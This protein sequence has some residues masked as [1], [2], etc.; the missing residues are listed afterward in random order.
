MLPPGSA[1][2]KNRVGVLELH[3]SL[4]FAPSPADQLN[5][6]SRGVRWVSAAT[7]AVG[8]ISTCPVVVN[9]QS[10]SDQ[11]GPKHREPTRLYFGMWTTHLKHDVVALHNNWVVG[12]TYRG[13]FGAT[14]LNS[15]GR[16]AFTGGIQRTILATEPRPIGASLGLRIGLVSGYDG[17]FMQIARDTPVLPFVQ[18]YVTLDVYRIGFEIQYT[19]VI[20]SVAASVRF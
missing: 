13:F 16:R 5:M 20:V 8:L 15:Y 18:P 4:V 6:Q 14:F 3:F 2:V 19:F 9:A 17:R 11:D 7:L 10:E 1:T 12:L